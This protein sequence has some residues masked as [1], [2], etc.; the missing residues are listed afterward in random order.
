[1]AESFFRN[2][3]LPCDPIY[4]M[5]CHPDG[6][7]HLGR[8]RQLTETMWSACCEYVDQDAPLRARG[9]FQAVWWELYLANSFRRAGI[10]LT[11][12]DKRARTRGIPDVV[13]INPRVWIEA[14]MPRLGE[15]SDQ[16]KEPPPGE[17]YNV[18]HDQF[19]LRLAAAIQEKAKKFDTYIANGTVQSSESMV[20]AVS[21]G[22]LPFKFSEAA[23]PRIVRALFGVGDVGVQLDVKS[24]EVVG[25]FV[26]HQDR[27]LKKAGAEVRTDAFLSDQFAHISA[28]LYS[29][30]DCVNCNCSPGDYFILVHNPYARVPVSKSW[31][32]ICDQYSVEENGIRRWHANA[33][34]VGASGG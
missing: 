3:E 33:N 16:L 18:P 24:G 29:A 9:D 10:E 5:L 17:V 28:V 21:G 14:V 8:A 32:R 7:E 6:Y 2:C 20:I 13:A 1:M 31:L 15:K 23:V 30:V 26:Q 27:V 19:V 34:S 4:Q 25:H 12:W 22:R 11:P